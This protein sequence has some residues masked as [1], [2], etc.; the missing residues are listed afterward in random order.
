[1]TS[2]TLSGRGG[3]GSRMLVAPADKGKYSPLPNP[4]AKKSFE[5]LKQRSLFVMFKTPFAYA[6][7]LTTISCCKWTHAFGRPVLPDE[8]NQKAASS[9]LVAAASRF[10]ELSDSAVSKLTM[11]G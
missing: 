6:S 11:S 3:P 10:D 1:M 4:Y 5:T 7:L 2:N 8:Y 9:L